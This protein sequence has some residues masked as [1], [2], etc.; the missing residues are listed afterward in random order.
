MVAVARRGRRAQEDVGH[1]AER[2]ELSSAGCPDLVP[3]SAGGETRR[4]RQRAIRPERRIAGIP[5]RVAME[6][7]Q[8]GVDH[9]VGAIAEVLRQRA[10]DA[11]GLRMRT[12]H[13]LRRPGRARCIHDILRVAGEHALADPAPAAEASAS[14]ARSTS[15]LPTCRKLSPASAERA[16]RRECRCS[17][18]ERLGHAIG[19]FGW[20]RR[21]RQESD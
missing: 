4:D 6:Q 14:A 13:A 10:A 16:R 18:A 7:R 3:E 5:E 11:M 19:P 17:A 2:I 20:R 9:V 21:R 8:A 1:R 12:D 15:G